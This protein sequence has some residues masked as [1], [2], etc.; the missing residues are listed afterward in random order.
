[1]LACLILALSFGTIAALQLV[2]MNYLHN[3]DPFH[4]PY[5]IDQRPYKGSE[6]AIAWVVWSLGAG[7]AAT[8][9]WAVGVVIADGH[10]FALCTLLLLNI[11]VIYQSF[12]YFFKAVYRKLFRG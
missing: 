2:A 11:M 3:L 9:M 5:D 10:A 4:S 12:D 6:I 1:M 8:A 7:I